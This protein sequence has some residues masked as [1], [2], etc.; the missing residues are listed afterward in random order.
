MKYAG[1]WKK[2]RTERSE[3]LEQ[4]AEPVSLY[5]IGHGVTSIEHF[6]WE[7]TLGPAV[8]STIKALL[9]DITE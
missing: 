7:M 6:H 4:D 2:L 1:N 9:N 5:L 3:L 8:L